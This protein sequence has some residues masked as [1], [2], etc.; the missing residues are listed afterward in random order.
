MNICP[1]KTYSSSQY[2]KNFGKSKK[3]DSENESSPPPSQDEG[4]SYRPSASSANKAGGNI[5][6]SLGL[7]NDP[8]E[9]V[10]T[11]RTAQKY[12]SLNMKYENILKTNPPT[13][14][15][16]PAAP[17][18][19]TTLPFQVCTYNQHLPS[20]FE[21]LKALFSLIKG[22]LFQ[23]FNDRCTSDDVFHQ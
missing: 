6:S 16:P 21:T 1:K 7:A 9:Y 15:P 10:M 20:T 12:K 11:P 5:V 3:D 4:K 18:A 2:L 17:Q 22:G 8:E 13:T 23:L 19:P 14:S